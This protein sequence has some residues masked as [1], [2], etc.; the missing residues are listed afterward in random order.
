MGILKGKTAI[1]IFA[2]KRYL[3]EKPYWGNHFWARVYFV[4]TVGVDEEMIKRYVKYLEKREKD[5][6]SDSKNY[7]LF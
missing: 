7:K 6:E 2:M 1:H 5:G 4:S 3:K